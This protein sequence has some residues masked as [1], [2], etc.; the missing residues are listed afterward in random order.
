MV[1]VRIS[2]VP[3]TGETVCQ[4]VG[5]IN[6]AHSSGH[7][8]DALRV[9]LSLAPPQLVLLDLSRATASPP[10]DLD[11]MIDEARRIHSH[12]Q[13]VVQGVPTPDNRVSSPATGR[14]AD[15]YWTRSTPDPPPAGNSST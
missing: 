4:V 14:T 3:G 5:S 1:R 6:D 11:P 12:R 13:I 8:A 7:L 10:V 2:S 15:A 9:A